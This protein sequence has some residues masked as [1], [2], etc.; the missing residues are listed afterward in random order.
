MSMWKSDY[1][2]SNGIKLHYT[3]TGGD[4]PPM[5]LA[6]GITDNGLC[7]TAV[8][9]VLEDAYDIVMVDARGHGKSDSPENGDYGWKAHAEDINGVVEGLGLDKPIVLGHSMGAMSALTYAALY[10]DSPRAI[11]LEDPSPQWEQPGRSPETIAERRQGFR[12]RILSLKDKTREEIIAL[13]REAEPGWSDKELEPWADAKIHVNVA[14]A[15][16]LI[17]DKNNTM[18]WSSKLPAVSCPTLLITAEV[19]RGAIVTLKAVEQVRSF[20]P[21][22]QVESVADAGHCIHRDEFDAYMDIV[23]NFLADL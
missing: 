5:V 7:W 6:H 11:L 22:I 12:D 13:Q 23:Q 18:D 14:V 15:D 8:A 20:I 4:K 16:L 9:E 1:V 10:P 21:H 17:R 19:D 3:R 2:E